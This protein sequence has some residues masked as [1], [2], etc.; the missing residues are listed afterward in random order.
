MIPRI[1]YKIQ[2]GEQITGKKQIVKK[3]EV[4]KKQHRMASALEEHKKNVHFGF[5]CLHYS[6]SEGS[7]SIAIVVHNK[8]GKAGSVGVAT[9]DGEAQADKDYKPVKTVLE[10]KAGEMEKHVD[11]GIIDDDDW[12]PDED[13]YVYLHDPQSNERLVGE[14]TRTT[15]TIIDD[16]KPGTLGFA[17]RSV[18][19][20]ASEKRVEIV[21]ERKDGC[22]G[23]ISCEWETCNLGE[24]GS[25]GREARPGED[26]KAGKG[27]LTFPHG[28]SEGK[29]EI[30]IIEKDQGT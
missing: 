25:S 14:D 30:E 4:L 16:D 21:V 1:K 23:E 20:I 3:K 17:T 28:Q 22:D 19:A 9:E 12:E 10:F 11:V 5:V 15:I 24:D 2:V 27:T 8:S 18:K 13:F 7:G 29:I 26:Y 6:V